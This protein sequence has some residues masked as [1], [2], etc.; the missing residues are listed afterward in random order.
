[1]ARRRPEV[2]EVPLLGW[3][4]W[5]ELNF[6]GRCLSGDNARFSELVIRRDH[7]EAEAEAEGLDSLC[8]LR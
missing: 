4:E 3:Q 7:V 5:H 8:T 6:D 1:M 2:G